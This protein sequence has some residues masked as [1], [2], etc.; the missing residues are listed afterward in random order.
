MRSG[1][2]MK[3]YVLSHT[4]E[5]ED[6]HGDIKVVGHFSTREKA[7]AA[8]KSV[9]LQPGFRDRP[10]SFEI[11]EWPIDPDRLE[12]AEGY[13]TAYPDGTFSN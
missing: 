9:R 12:W 11:S 2:G 3:I 8:L 10:S 4:H 13:V 6:D 5:W 7:E 1:S